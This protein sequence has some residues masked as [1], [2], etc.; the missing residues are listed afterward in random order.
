MA[1]LPIAIASIIKDNKIL[2]IKRTRGEFIGFWALPG[3]KIEHGEHVSETAVREIEEET[4]LKTTFK[5]HLGFVSEHVVEK[6]EIKEHFLM[7][8]CALYPETTAITNA[9]VAWFDLEKIQDN[10]EV[11]PSD[12][13]MI[14]KIIKNREKTYYDCVQEKV[15]DVYH[16]RKFE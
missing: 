11:I 12:R 8:I 1:P 4:G 15:N 10:E 2:L 7:H 6:E 14:D 9:N 16:L 5:E 3:G 13:A